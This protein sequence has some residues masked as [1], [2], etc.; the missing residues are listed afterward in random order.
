MQKVFFSSYSGKA[1]CKIRKDKGYT[2]KE[3]ASQFNLSQQQISRYERGE[4]QLTID[5]FFNV[6]IILDIS[7]P[8]FIN[9]LFDEIVLNHPD[10]LDAVRLKIEPLDS[11]FLIWDKKH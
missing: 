11:M 10:N 2:G 4:N 6:F 7:L 9:Y 5:M 3:L 8:S 1:I